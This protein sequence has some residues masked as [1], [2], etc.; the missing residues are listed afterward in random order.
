MVADAVAQKRVR[1]D[2]KFFRLGEQKFFIKGVAYGPFAPN[3]E[4][5]PFASRAQTESDFKQMVELGANLLRVYNTPPRWFLDLASLHGLRI[6]ID[7]LWNKERC[8]LD[9][10]K[11][12]EFARGAVRET[13]E[14][15]LSHPAVFAYSLV[16]EIPADIVRWSGAEEIADF[17]DELALIA[18]EIDPGCLCTFG[19]FPPTEFLRP[20]L[21]DFVSFNVYLHQQRAYE[22]YMARLQMIA[23]E[24]PLLIGEFGIDSMREGEEAK[25]EILAWQIETGFRAGLAG[26]IVFTYTDDWFAGGSQVEEWFMGLTT[27][28]R[29]PKPSFVAVQKQFRAAPYFLL[30]RYPKVSVVVACYNGAKTLKNCLDS[31]QT[32]HYPDYE[33]ILVDDGSTDASGQIASLYSEVQYIRQSNKGLSVARNTGIAAATGEVIAFTDADCRADEDWLYY[34][35]GDLV[36]HPLAGIGGHNFLPP[37]DA[38]VAAAVM[39]SPGGPAHVM[40]TDQVAEHIPG[41][42]MAFFRWALEEIGGFDPIFAKAGDDVDV[43]W[44]LQQRGHSIGFNPAGFVW[45]YRRSTV[46]AYLKQQSGY[47]EAEALLVRKH[48]EYFSFLGGSIWRGRIYSSSRL[49]VVVKGPIIYHG[50]FGTAF[51]Q[52]LY[53]SEPA[54]SLMLFTSL[55]YHVLI[56]VPLLILSVPFHFLWPVAL[57]S[58]L[59]SAGVCIAAAVQARLPK[60]KI[61]WWSRPLVAL[62]FFLQPIG[63][64]WAR[65]QGR[66]TLRPTPAAAQKQLATVQRRAKGP[67]PDLTFYW[68]KRSI[69]RL[70]FINVLLARLDR[71]GWPSKADQGWCDFDVEIY[72]SR[73]NRLQLTIASEQWAGENKMFRCRL[74]GAWSLPAKVAFWSLCGFELLIIGVLSRDLPYIWMLLLTLPIF[75]WYFEQEKQNFQRLMAA[76]VDEIAGEMKMTSL[77]YKEAEE[78]FSVV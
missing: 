15:C 78:K 57:I 74:R 45:H 62:L 43:C 72:G 71:D 41:C 31:L 30:S 11:A 54:L 12:R 28:D 60:D 44:R 36:Q 26:T 33:V 77:E 34:L 6:F 65:Y 20:Q 48:P 56:T 46:K 7:I 21:M 64:G 55:E 73:W 35:M 29:K 25:C 68:A 53:A 49:G 1:V 47:G 38:P 13:V 52:T 37:E 32:L 66:L 75:G 10:E 4:K 14:A 67:P 59:I 8:F 9:S 22:K 70:T 61:R 16:N 18:K 3:S 24:K 27:V 50:L 76:L 5:E 19:N 23:G 58:L 17:I 40:L 51:F 63:R 39:A 2:G 42:N 69:D